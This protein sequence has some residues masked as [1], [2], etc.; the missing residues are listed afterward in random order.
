ME[1]PHMIRVKQTFDATTLDNIYEEIHSQ[2][3]NLG[4][5]KVIKKGQTVAVACSSR[6]LSN[7]PIIVKAVISALKQTDLQPFIIPAMGSHGAATAEGQKRV[8]EH[9]GINETEVGAPIKSSLEVVQIGETDDQI[10]VYLDKLAAEADHMVL[11]NRIKKHTEF[12]HEFESGLI[13]MMGIGIGKQAGAATY[14]E[15]M[16]TYGYPHVLLT[17]AHKIMEHSNLLFGVGSVENGYG[18]TATIGICPRD[19]LEDMEKELLKTAKAYAP[20]LP[21]DEADIIILDE[22]GKDISGTGF[23]TKVVGRIGLPLVT[24]DPESPKIK[25]IVVCDLTAGSE[26]NAVGVGIAD[27]ITRRLLDKIDMDALNINTITG[28]CPEM[29]KIPLT[30]KNDKEAIEVAIK[31]VGLIPCDR[32]KIIRIKN[33]SFLSEVEVSEAYEEELASRADLEVIIEKRAMNF[34]TDGNLLP[35]FT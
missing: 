31:C 21:F 25:R 16:L 5:E 1:L 20:G 28:V 11:I 34:D 4:L 24:N 15:A 23:D 2:V 10:P 14:H 17:V 3:E 18:R 8:L 7:Y 32:L 29:G 19:R 13:K 22:L 26:G 27:V 30:M 9:L 6:G 33:T 12:D 35:F